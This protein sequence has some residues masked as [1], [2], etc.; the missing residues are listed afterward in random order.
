MQQQITWAPILLF[1]SVLAAFALIEH[2]RT[3]TKRKSYRSGFRRMESPRARARKR[4]QHGSGHQG[5]ARAQ[6]RGSHGGFAR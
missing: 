6:P 3:R 5:F 2:L 1:L 4:A